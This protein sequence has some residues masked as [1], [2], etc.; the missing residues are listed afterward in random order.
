MKG[1]HSATLGAS[2]VRRLRRWLALG[3]ALGAL[4]GCLSPTLPLP[5]PDIPQSITQ[6]P[7]GSWQIHGSCIAG[8]VVT[9]L[10]TRTGRGSVY[11]D[12]DRSGSY[13]V[14][15]QAMQ[16][17]FVTVKQDAHNEESADTGFLLQVYSQ[18]MPGSP[19]AC[20]SGG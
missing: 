10:D 5:P 9:V 1:T 7:D 16:C 8:A 14:V 11:E 13:T 15:L 19:N 6:A 18:G 4:A 12:L 3:G 17:D 2:M 20:P